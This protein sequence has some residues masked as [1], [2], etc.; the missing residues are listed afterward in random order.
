M[1]KLDA[2]Q[3][4]AA[5]R[6]ILEQLALGDT[7]RDECLPHLKVDDSLSNPPFSDSDWCGELLKDD[8]RWV[9]GTPRAGNASYARVQ[10]SIHH[11]APTGVA[12]FVLA[13]GS[14]ASSQSGEGE[15]FH[16]T[17]AGAA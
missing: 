6:G 16:E 14:M 12:G 17:T 4:N 10:R 5:V 1:I 2:L 11:L 8:E 7:L 15:I 9:Y 13:S 3:P